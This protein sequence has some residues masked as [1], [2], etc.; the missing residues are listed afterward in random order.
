MKHKIEP[1]MLCLV[2]GGHNAGRECTVIRW[3]NYGDPISEFKLI[4]H[5]PGWFI[6]GPSLEGRD[7]NKV[8]RFQGIA[9][10]DQSWLIPINGIA[11]DSEDAIVKER[12]EVS[13]CG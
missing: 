9:I 8:I 5:C 4:A 10:A 7:A 12:D 13:V 2:I 3:V 1:G 6:K 11:D